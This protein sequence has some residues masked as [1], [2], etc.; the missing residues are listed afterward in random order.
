MDRPTDD[1]PTDDEYANWA[2]RVG[3]ER[4]AELYV[5]SLREDLDDALPRRD[6][7]SEES[8][9][10][11]IVSFGYGLAPREWLDLLCRTAD[12]AAGDDQI[13][14]CIGDMGVQSACAD[15]LIRAGIRAARDVR[16]GVHRMFTVMRAYY[17]GIGENPGGWADVDL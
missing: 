14:W 2:R 8:H 15:P 10:Q 7:D 9:S 3:F 4:V 1:E 16:P 12:R 6:P 13:L 17:E 11:V 5:R